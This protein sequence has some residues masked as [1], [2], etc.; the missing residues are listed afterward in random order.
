M[1]LWATPLPPPPLL[2]LLLQSAPLAKLLGARGQRRGPRPEPRRRLPVLL[3]SCVPP[4]K[5]E[6][7]A[8][9]RNAALWGPKN[10]AAT[11]P[12]LQE[13]CGASVSRVWGEVERCGT[14]FAARTGCVAAAQERFDDP[15]EEEG[16]GGCIERLL[17]V[18]A[19]RKTARESR[20]KRGGPTAVV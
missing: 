17:E 20:T 18:S 9:L 6:Q 15:E 8:M 3:E 13:F 2:L 12:A 7:L 16:V 19:E 4:M 5:G 1:W 14:W 10:V 11:Y